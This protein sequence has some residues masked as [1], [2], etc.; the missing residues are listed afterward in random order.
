MKKITL[1][2]FAVV[3]SLN[4]HAQ[5]EAFQR[6]P[7]LPSVDLK[8]LDGQ[9]FN[10][11]SM[12]N[13]GKPII[14]S[15]W[16]TWCMPCREELEAI[17]IVY[18]DWVE[19]TGVK[20]YAV[21]IDDSRTASKVAPFVRSKGW[22]YVILQDINSDF[23]RALN[24]TDVPYLCIL[25]GKREIVWAHTSYAAGD[26]EEIYEIIKKLSTEEK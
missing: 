18:E 8:T 14:I 11:Q 12:D 22:E 13:E 24:V 6:K 17:S 25:N 19:E 21:S 16:A 7:T 5:K 23:K 15:L 9:I 4:I 1:F 10:T 3:L 20:L 2:L 26:E